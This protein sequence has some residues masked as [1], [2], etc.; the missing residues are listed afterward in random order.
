MSFTPPS[1]AAEVL[2][3]LAKDKG[4]MK[5]LIRIEE[6]DGKRAVSARELHEFLGSK[7]MFSNWMK[8]RINK[9]GLQEGVDYEAINKFVKCQNGIGGV[10]S[11]EYALTLDAAKEL[12]MVEGNEKG[13]E[14]RRYF[15]EIEKRHREVV[16]KYDHLI[17]RT[18][19]EALRLAA[20]QAEELDRR[21][22]LIEE[23]RSKN[24]ELSEK[25][26][27]L[28]KENEEN[29]RKLEEQLPKVRLAN[30][31]H[32]TNGTCSVQEL[33]K[34]LQQNGVQTGPN[35]L[36]SWLRENKYLCKTYQFKNLPTQRAM[37]MGLFEVTKKRFVD[38]GGREAIS[39]RTMVTPKGQEY[40]VN[41]LINNK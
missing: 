31:I 24:C 28:A 37:T 25:N 1:V 5:E 20:D 27:S 9:F 40:F 22:K 16:A 32:A 3:I 2:V 17:P 18:Y 30:A 13:K 29:E 6:R 23:E 21:Q 19:V 26:D 33:A 36:Y 10:N 34:V 11:V 41:L 12:A 35:R 39:A 14:A 38:D 8:S 15:I 7:R 4:H